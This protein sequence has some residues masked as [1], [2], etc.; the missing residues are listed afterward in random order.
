MVTILL[1]TKKVILSDA[2]GACGIKFKRGLGIDYI[3]VEE[4]CSFII[5]SRGHE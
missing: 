4:L 5:L 3:K 2:F 1:I